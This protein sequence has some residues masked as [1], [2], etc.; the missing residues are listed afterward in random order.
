MRRETPGDHDHLAYR[1]LSLIL[2][3]GGPVGAGTLYF[4][5]QHD[6]MRLSAP[7]IGRRLRELEVRGLLRKVTME[8]RV[9][10]PKGLRVLT[11]LE[12][13]RRLQAAGESLLGALRQGGKEDILDLLAARRTIEGEV[14]RLAAQRVTAGDLREMD[15]ILARQQALVG[16]GQLAVHEDIRFHETLARASG[17]RFLQV[18]VSL[19]RHHGQFSY[20][21]THIRARSGSKLVVDHRAILEAVKARD[22]ARAQAAMDR[23]LTALMDEVTT[24]WDELQTGQGRPRRYQRKPSYAH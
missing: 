24:Y 23:H 3:H 14:A 11:A 1:L 15:A 13:E 19:L 16:Q 20:L 12:H 21:V 18:L 8:G 22:P 2:A 4:R 5:L 17:N 9:I 7:T 10:T 6:G